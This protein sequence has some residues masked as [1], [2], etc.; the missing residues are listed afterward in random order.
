MS[1]AE[2]LTW[3]HVLAAITWV[4]GATALVILVY[5]AGATRDEGLLR[6]LV[7]QSEF[8]GRY[9]FTI[10][11]IVVLVAGVWLV[12]E[13]DAWEFSQGFISIGFAGIALGAVLGMAFYPKL[14]RQVGEAVDSASIEAPTA[15]KA[16]RTLRGVASLE[17]AILAFV[18]WSM[19]TKPGL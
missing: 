1:L 4:G 17:M 11:S 7:T 16:L 3:I 2:F 12:I 8:L 19:V 15:Q 18:V 10:S 6:G 14:W 13:V 5:R 9:V